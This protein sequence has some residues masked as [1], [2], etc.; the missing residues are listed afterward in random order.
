M[1]GCFRHVIKICC[2][3]LSH[4][5]DR[6][7]R[8]KVA[9]TFYIFHSVAETSSQKFMITLNRTKLKLKKKKNRTIKQYIF[10]FNSVLQF[11]I[12]ILLQTYCGLKTLQSDGSQ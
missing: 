8:K 2:D 5:S 3:F 1:E 11:D 9:I 7:T 10:F 6:I 12:A 4:K